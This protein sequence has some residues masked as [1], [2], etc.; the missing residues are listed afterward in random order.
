MAS[1]GPDPQK[2]FYGQLASGAPSTTSLLPPSARGSPAGVQATFARGPPSLRS[3]ASVNSLNESPYNSAA[4]GRIASLPGGQSISDKFSL[5]PDPSSWGADISPNHPEP[6]DFLHNPDPRRDHRKDRGGSILTYRGFANL[7]CLIVLSLGL[8]TLFGGYPLISHFTANRISY[9]G[10]F[11]IGGI[12]ASGQVPAI[13]NN[14]GLIDNDTPSDAHTIKSFADGS[15]WQLVFSDEFNQDGRT[16][17]PGDDPYWEA[18]DLHYWQ[19]GDLEWYYPEAIT[20]SGGALQVQ[21]SE[22][23]INNLDYQGGMMTSWNKFCFT[24][25]M[26]LVS[27]SLPGYNNVSGLWPAI[28]TMGNLGRV[29]Y[30]ASTDGTWPY[31]YDACDVGTAPNQTHDGKP[32]AALENGDPY[33]GNVLSYLPGQRL[34]RCTCP[35]ESHPGPMHSDG[36]YVGRAAPEIDIFEA[37]L[38]DGQGA[39]SQSGQWAPMNAEY[40][41]FNTTGNY[42]IPNPAITSQNTYSG[43]AYQQATS[44][45]TNLTE[46]QCYTNETGC[47][48]TLGIE[49]KPGYTQDDAYISWIANDE[50]AWTLEA[51]AMAADS[52]VEISARPITQE[53]MYIIFNLGLSPSFAYID[54]DNLPFPTVMSVDW[55]RVYQPKDSINVGCDPADFP[56]A[57]YINEYTEAYTNPNL[58]TWTTDYKQT[59]PKN[60]FLGQC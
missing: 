4:A 28:W 47:Y 24:G 3:M 51:S 43:G 10:G 42:V 25:G 17:W 15:E 54:T 6:D 23:Q 9:G 50:V 14:F 34:S 21:L 37:L 41:W 8:L 52:R 40:D 39:V 7:G 32:L 57:A 5:S 18:V 31:N 26:V 36:T 12:N 29:G 46:Q 59:F 20:T 45:L 19:T 53:P 11:N 16:F 1:P 30:G 60:S 49:F 2:R 55:I 44:A 27:V 58:T 22:K 48:Q 33:N 56:T 38:L 13:P 35:G